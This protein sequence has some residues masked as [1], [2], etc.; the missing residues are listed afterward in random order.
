MEVALKSETI[1]DLMRH[2]RK[3][4]KMSQLDL[5]LETDV[6]TRHLSFVESGRA[7][8]SRELLQRLAE[9]LSMP[10]RERDRLLIAGGYAPVHR[11]R[12]LDEPAMQS[13]LMAI[14]TVLDATE[15]YPALVVDRLWNLV[16]ANRPAQQL[17][18]GLPQRL[19][20]PPIS[21]L[22]AT[23]D[24]DGLAPRIVNLIEWRHHLLGR[25]RADFVVT[26]DAELA[27]L[28][29]ELAAIPVIRSK[30][31]PPEVERVAVPLMLRVPNGPV[32]SLIS[33]TTVF[34]TAN[35][36]TLSELT[37]ESFF[38][39]DSKTRDFFLAGQRP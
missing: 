22:R 17:L 6:S 26:A 38:P 14:N 35:D 4:R 21:V 10:L 24:P 32:L 25:L 27:K 18:A 28:H 8:A 2:W 16:R 39:A 5:A 37:L 9:R 13:A 3:C 7:G 33:T 11:A 20:E 34:G 29:D 15:P 1:G 19:S 36:V 31:P 30:A 12:S 23:L